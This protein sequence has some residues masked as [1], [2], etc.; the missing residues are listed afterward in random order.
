LAAFAGYQAGAGGKY[1][2]GE[3]L[4][5]LGLAAKPEDIQSSMTDG[6]KQLNLAMAICA[7]FGGKVITRK[8]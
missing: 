6:D 8:E 2:F 1:T 3:Y 4:D 5:K 7:A